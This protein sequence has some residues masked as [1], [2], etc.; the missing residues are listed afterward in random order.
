MN[1]EV[2]TMKD[3]EKIANYDKLVEENKI[4]KEQRNYHKTEY[5]MLVIKFNKSNREKDREIRRL[6]KELME[7]RNEK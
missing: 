4:L 1:Y 3:A 2:L 5:N 7:A 6:E